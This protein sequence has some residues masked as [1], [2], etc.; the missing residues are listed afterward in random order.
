MALGAKAKPRLSGAQRRKIARE[1]KAAAARKKL[2]NGELLEK[3]DLTLAP[4]TYDEWRREGR[5]V[6]WE[7]RKGKIPMDDGRALTWA[8]EINGR[9]AKMSEELTYLRE[10][11]LRL[12][13]AGTRTTAV[14]YLPAL[15]T[16]NGED[17]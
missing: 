14:D 17:E 3:C 13:E 5:E 6:Y 8:A 11:N 9:L 4:N 16:P 15:E 12:Q 1:Q 10:M 7:M 2:S